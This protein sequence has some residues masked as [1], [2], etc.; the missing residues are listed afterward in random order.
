[1]G[2]EWTGLQVAPNALFERKQ[3]IP[4]AKCVLPSYVN[5]D[6]KDEGDASLPNLELT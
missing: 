2:V 6:E 5:W 1:M 4:E 3:S